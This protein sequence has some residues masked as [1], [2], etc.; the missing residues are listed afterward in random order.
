MQACGLG[1][2]IIAIK[3]ASLIDAIFNSSTL[4][5]GD[6]V[7]AKDIMNMLAKESEL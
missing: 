5:D 2:C 3:C 6:I 1:L 4:P 7:E